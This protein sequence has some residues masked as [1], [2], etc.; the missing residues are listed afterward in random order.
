MDKINANELF[1]LEEYADKVVSQIIVDRNRMFEAYYNM[2][3]NAVKEEYRVKLK[4]ASNSDEE[5]FS[6]I[7]ITEYNRFAPLLIDER[8]LRR[9]IR[10]TGAH[11]MVAI[12]SWQENAPREENYDTAKKL[13]ADIKAS[14]YGYLPF[15]NDYALSF[16]V[17]D[18]RYSE[19][20]NILEKIK[21]PFSV[22]VGKSN[23]WAN[24][25]CQ[26]CVLIKEHEEDP[27]CVDEN[28]EETT[29]NDNFMP[30][31]MS[32][33]D[34]NTLKKQLISVFMEKYAAYENACAK[35]RQT[36][37]PFSVWYD[38]QNSLNDFVNKKWSYDIK[39][40]DKG[41]E[42]KI[43][44]NPFARNIVEGM[45]RKHEFSHWWI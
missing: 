28:G 5:T 22:L 35:S 40:Y 45:I 42:A 39:N 12:S 19:E 25:Y 14:R 33:E 18:Y 15:Y 16:I 10:N 6:M 30:L 37:V 38:E 21:T 36:P 7:F 20:G 9:I 27:V 1:S 8:L 11:D 44:L 3:Y 24:K 4:A 29:A 32:L 41:T 2:P 23:E 13:L 26:K 31:F 17:F 34:D 43:Y